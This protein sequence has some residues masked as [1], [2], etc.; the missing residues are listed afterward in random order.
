M[1]TTGFCRRCRRSPGD[2]HLYSPNPSPLPSGDC[3]SAKFLAK[4]IGATI[5]IL[6]KQRRL[7]QQRLASKAGTSR[8]AITKLESGK[9]IP[10][11]AKLQRVTAALGME[12]ADLFL[13][14]SRR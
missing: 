12:L 8:P 1:T 14:L 7:S 13:G 6:R 4:R 9:S 5:R 11:L 3:L 10:T 2:P